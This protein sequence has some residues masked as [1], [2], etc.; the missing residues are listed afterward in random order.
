MVDKM[1]FHEIIFF[2]GLGRISYFV[3]TDLKY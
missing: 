3:G 2:A 1:I